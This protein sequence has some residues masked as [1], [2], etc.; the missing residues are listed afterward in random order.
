MRKIIRRIFFIWNFDDEEA[1][2]NEMAAK[3]MNLVGVSLG[4][5]EFEDGTP[6][7]YTYRL[8]M[9]NHWASHPESQNY[10]R[11]I[12]ETGAEHIGTVKTWVFF[13]KKVTD[14]EFNIFSDIDSK[15]KHLDRVIRLNT[16]CLCLELFWFLFMI[17]TVIINH[18]EESDFIKGFL[19]SGLPVS[20]MMIALVVW[21]ALGLVKSIN[22]KKQLSKERSLHE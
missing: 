14:G 7:E 22:K 13:R 21:M 16:I 18:G 1:W 10:I 4:R 6:G 2:I 20:G 12:E 9:L 5:Y 8:E 15:I 3:G 11:F 19:T 17:S